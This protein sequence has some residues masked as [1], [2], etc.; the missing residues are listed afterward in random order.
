MT[1]PK[2]P[3][4]EYLERKARRDAE[5]AP[6]MAILVKLWESEISNSY[7]PSATDFIVWLEEFGPDETELAIR[8]AASRNTGDH[9]RRPSAQIAYITGI[10]RNRKKARE[11]RG[12]S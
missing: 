10:L 1:E 2:N 7:V 12:A 3:F 4:G 6:V 11:S 9:R 5:Y 8:I